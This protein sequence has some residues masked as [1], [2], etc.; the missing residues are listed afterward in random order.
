[1]TAVTCPTD[2]E[3]LAVGDGS[4]L[5]TTD[6]GASWTQ[7]T[8]GLVQS[9]GLQSV[10]CATSTD[11]VAVGERA[12][13]TGLVGIAYRTTDGGEEWSQATTPSESTPLES[14]ACP[15]ATLCVAVA[16]RA[17][18]PILVST[19]AGATWTVASVPPD[20]S[21][22]LSSVSCGTPTTCVAVGGPTVAVTTD[23][24]S[25]WTYV[26]PVLAGENPVME[27]VNCLSS[28]DCVAVASTYGSE[29]YTIGYVYSTTDGGSSWTQLSRLPG[30]G[31]P[32]ISC[33]GENCNALSTSFF[34]PAGSSLASSTDG[35]T[36]W[37]AMSLPSQ[38]V[39][40]RG[41]AFMPDGQSVVVGSD[42]ANGALVISN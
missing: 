21:A 35:A 27:S 7:V 39:L 15:S 4:S 17:P 37:S 33:S 31:V 24:G 28:A 36:T 3:C 38:D 19:D 42:P 1:M 32:V 5:L 10:T 26:R 22:S 20:S 41:I 29:T 9:D 8:T 16:S 30:G 25:S 14:V 11:C 40:L 12:T 13:D 34:D 23:A 18:E 6:G 2:E